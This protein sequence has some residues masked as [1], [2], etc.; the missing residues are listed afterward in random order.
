VGNALRLVGI[1]LGLGL[2]AAL[3]LTLGVA[4]SLPGVVA[5][6]PFT[7]AGFSVLLATAALAAS[8]IPS[9]RATRIDPVTALRAE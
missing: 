4:S 9:Q 1:G 6:D 8:F 7:F 2:P 3:A 5:L